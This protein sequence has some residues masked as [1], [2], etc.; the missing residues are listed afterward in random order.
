MSELVE[1]QESGANCAVAA[2]VRARKAAGMPAQGSPAAAFAAFALLLGLT[3][4][5]V[6]STGYVNQGAEQSDQELTANF[7]SHETRFD[8][9]VQML[10]AD[11]SRL[12]AQGKTSIDLATVA[13]RGTSVARLRRYRGL[14]QQI[15]VE[16]F[17]YFPD[18]GKLVLA[19]NGRGIP[20]RPSKSYLYLPRAQ[21]Q[22]LA[23]YHGYTW[24][25]PAVYVLTG[26]RP[27]KGSW[28][29]HHDSAVAVAISPF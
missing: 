9:L 15:S 14:L 26:D 1:R 28:F 10:T 18:S 17:R 21:P 27:L 23:Q 22:S 29:I 3:T 7:F 11:R 16:D 5:A 12:A 19:P 13:R 4:V 25:G 2:V 24:R 8:E 20:K 6:L